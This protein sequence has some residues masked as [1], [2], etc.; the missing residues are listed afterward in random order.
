M[1]FLTKIA[2]RQPANVQAQIAQIKSAGQTTVTPSTQGVPKVVTNVRVKKKILNSTQAQL[3]VSFTQ[4][5][6]D[7]YF[8]NAQIYLKLAAGNPVLIGQG[9]NS[10]LVITV[11]RTSTPA[12]I[13][14]VSAGNW[15]STAISASPVESINLA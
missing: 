10:P 8:V 12:T 6:G 15:G 3:T 11:A 13:I 7:P 9:A 1:S 4:N 5:P 14:V 2:P